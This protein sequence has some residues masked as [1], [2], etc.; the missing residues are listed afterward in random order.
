VNRLTVRRSAERELIAAAAWYD[1]Q[2]AGLGREFLEEIGQ[3]FQRIRESPIAYPQWQPDGPYRKF[4][5]QRF[6]YLV[7]Y[8]V[9]GSDKSVVAV[10]HGRR[11]PGYWAVRKG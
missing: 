1:R 7:F 2:Q 11:R 5:V 3:A 6:P 4:V 10:A 9:N 8:V